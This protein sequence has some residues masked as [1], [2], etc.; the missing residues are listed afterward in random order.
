[1]LK[2][3]LVSFGFGVAFVIANLCV[4]FGYGL[5]LFFVS[6]QKMDLWTLRLLLGPLLLP[7]IV[8]EL[9]FGYQPA[10]NTYMAFIAVVDIILYGMIALLVFKVKDRLKAKRTKQTSPGPPPPSAFEI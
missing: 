9:I 6:K 5:L 2:R 1:M 8:Y 3:V 4:V 7:A 10:T